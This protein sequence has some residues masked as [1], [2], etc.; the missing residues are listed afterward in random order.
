ME[1]SSAGIWET[2]PSPTRQ[3]AVGVDGLADREVVLEDADGEAADQVDDRD[4]DGGDGVALDELGG[5]VHGPVEVGLGGESPSP[6]AGPRLSLMSPEFRSASMAICLPGM[7]SRVN[8]A[9]TSATRPAP[10][11]ITTNWMT[12]RMRKID[13]ADDERAADDEVAE[14]LDHRAGVA[15]QEHQPGGADVEGRAGTGWRPGAA[16]GRRR[17]RA[18]GCTCMLTSRISTAAVMLRR[19]QEVQDDRRHRHDHHHD[20]GD[21]GGRD[22]DLAETTGFHE[23]PCER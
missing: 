22:A 13:Q 18:A 5:A 6:D 1:S 15:V 14:A 20:D 21:D 8:R 17:S 11:V 16:R 9:A 2:R 7:A 4:D 12:I 3:Q 19:D 23:A 10:L